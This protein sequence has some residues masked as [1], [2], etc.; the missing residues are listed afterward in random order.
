MTTMKIGTI[1]QSENENYPVRRV[2][3][4]IVQELKSLGSNYPLQIFETV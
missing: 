4:G 3:L 1:R 2:F